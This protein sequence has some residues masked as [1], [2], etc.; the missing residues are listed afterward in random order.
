VL[1]ANDFY[2]FN[3][4]L[5]TGDN[6]MKR[7][8]LT[9]LTAITIAASANI[10]NAGDAAAGKAKS[11]VCAGCHGVA[12][13]SAVPMYPNLAGQKEAY[14]VKQ[15]TAFK[16]G[17]RTDPIMSGMAKPL[18]DDDVANLAAFFSSLK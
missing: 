4:I 18:S 11:V 9:V 15:L 6:Y 3:S 12:G 16:A 8:F 7:H 1:Q 10:A 14:I 5:F 17:T 13:I 2:K